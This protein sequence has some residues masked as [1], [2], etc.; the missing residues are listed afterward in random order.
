MTYILPGFPLL[1]S[2]ANFIT[3]SILLVWL[4]YK[5]VKWGESAS[6]IYPLPFLCHL[7]YLVAQIKDTH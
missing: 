5:P 3:Y 6:T 7:L 2:Y 4:D 1:S